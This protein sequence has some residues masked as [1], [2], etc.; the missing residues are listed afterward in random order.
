[1]QDN[2]AKY[3]QAKQDLADVSKGG[4]NYACCSFMDISVRLERLQE[5]KSELIQELGTKELEKIDNRNI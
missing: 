3:N 4:K 2:L 1:M 5:A